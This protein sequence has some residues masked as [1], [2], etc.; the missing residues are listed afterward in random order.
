MVQL[1]PITEYGSGAGYEYEDTLI[2]GF[3]HTNKGHW[4]LCN[5]PILPLS[6]GG[7]KSSDKF[8]SRFSHERESSAPGFY[9]VYLDDYDVDVHLTSTLR[10]GYHRYAYED[11]AGRQILFDLAKANNKVSNW[12]IEQVGSSVVQGYQQT[13]EKI[14]FYAILNTAIERVEKKE[15]G[16]SNGFAVVH[17]VNGNNEPVELKIGL[18]FVSIEN[19][20]QNLQ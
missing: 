5:I 7:Q 12:Q 6:D 20:K 3:T 13:G 11:N 16:A 1:S 4:N 15:E 17:L 9:Q 18:S 10:C 19:A 2:Y 14:Y 8:R